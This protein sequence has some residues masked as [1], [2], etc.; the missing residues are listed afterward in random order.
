V[1]ENRPRNNLRMLNETLERASLRAWPALVEERI[2]PWLFRC[3]LGFT[4]RAN[5]ATLVSRAGPEAA[6][7][8]LPH[9]EAR[10]EA[11][12]Q[13]PIFRLP[14]FTVT[15]ATDELLARR[16]YGREDV[17]LVLH[18]PAASHE[19]PGPPY[20]LVEVEVH[21][22]LAVFWSW[23][24]R[25]PR[26]RPIHERILR[27]IPATP[28]YAILVSG[29][30]PVSCGLG[31]LDDGCCGLFDLVTAPA[32]RNRGFGAALVHLMLA[33][34]GGM[35]AAHAYLQVVEGNAAA[36]HLYEKLGFSEVYRYW[37]RVPTSGVSLAS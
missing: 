4:K 30:Q 9:C 28:L 8:H 26:D 33:W 11:A 27:S 12:G 10:Y 19:P 36:R 23:S 32:A 24:P 14:S 7:E 6:A 16:G 31:V 13:P 29:E 17:T 15:S 1:S 20:R 25:D 21:D 34:A 35:K 2:G 5:S 18:R 22:W 37:Y 3:S